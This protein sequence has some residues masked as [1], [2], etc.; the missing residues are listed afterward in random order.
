[1]ILN[2]FLTLGGEVTRR[3]YSAVASRQANVVEGIFVSIEFYFRGKNNSIQHVR[4]RILILLTT[5]SHLSTSHEASGMLLTF[6]T[7]LGL[8]HTHSPNFKQEE[9]EE[10]HWLVPTLYSSVNRGKNEL[11][12][13]A[14]RSQV[15]DCSTFN[16][17]C[18]PNQTIRISTRV[19][20]LFGIRGIYEVAQ[21][22]SSSSIPQGLTVVVPT[23]LRSRGR[24]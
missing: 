21:Q 11:W 16:Q 1:M 8:R 4:C 19:F 9:K 22:S 6:Y 15:R 5:A 14:F 3:G 7:A 10:N 2:F 12:V 23:R 18:T 20:K 13:S 17:P 24:P